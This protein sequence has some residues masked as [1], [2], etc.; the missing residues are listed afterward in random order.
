MADKVHRNPIRI[1]T[2][3]QER[4]AEAI[5]AL[6]S[7]ELLYNRNNKTLGIILEDEEGNNY[8]QIVSGLVDEVN[9]T[10]NENYETKLKEDIVIDSVTTQA[11]HNGVDWKS[12]S[13]FAKTSDGTDN[14]GDPRHVVL[15]CKQDLEKTKG[16]AF[17][18]GEMIEVGTGIYSHYQVS[19]TS[20]GSRLIKGASTFAKKAK[21]VIVKYNPTGEYYY[22][23]KF[24]S[25]I[26]ANIYFA[27]WADFPDE[28]KAPT[29]TEYGDSDVSELI[30]LDDDSDTGT[31]VVDIIIKPLVDYTWEFYDGYESLTTVSKSWTMSSITLS[32]RNS[33]INFK[34]NDGYSTGT[35]GYYYR[36]SFA[37]IE[38]SRVY[39]LGTGSTVARYNNYIRVSSGAGNHMII[40]VNED[41]ATISI[42]AYSSGNTSTGSKRT[43]RLVNT[44]TGEIVGEAKEINAWSD[45]T[46]T[47]VG[48]PKG[49]YYVYASGSMYY[50][51]MSLNGVAS[52]LNETQ[53]TGWTQ[54]GNNSGYDLG[55]EL[56]LLST[57]NTK[58]YSTNVAGNAGYII[59]PRGSF[60]DPMLSLNVYGN[61]SV[62][63]GFTATSNGNLVNVRLTES[64]NTQSSKWNSSVSRDS[65]TTSTVTEVTYTYTGNYGDLAT[66]YALAE[67]GAVNLLYVKLDY[68]AVG[69]SAGERI[70]N[71]IKMLPDTGED[72]SAHILR[73]TATLFK[74]DILTIA[75]NCLNTQCQIELDLSNCTVGGDATDWR[76]DG[77]LSK[78]FQGCSSLRKFIYP[79][80]VLSAGGMTFLNCAYLRYLV[81]NDECTAIGTGTTWT[82]ANT[83]CL[84]GARTNK[85]FLP[86]EL[87][88]WGGY[89][90]AQNNCLEFYFYPA[91]WYIRNGKGPADFGWVWNTFS[92][93]RGDFKFYLPSH[94]TSEGVWATTDDDIECYNQWKGVSKT[95]EGT[96]NTSLSDVMSNVDALQTTDKWADFVEPYDINEF[97]TEEEIA[98]F[99]AEMK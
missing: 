13:L 40:G 82:S 37:E 65:S 24:F 85:L 43:L 25:G 71:C 8:R 54:N 29:Y 90:F 23:I 39:F 6:K 70:V 61:C 28:L 67:T 45:T 94:Q 44:T 63:L 3:T 9:I 89:F 34:N 62:T 93:A 73:P 77:D 59:F 78:A 88:D 98:A 97:F 10:K 57:G 49:D 11:D 21:F 68:T 58:W 4:E 72:G 41:S 1:A 2:T 96:V 53:P 17:I 81:F 87:Q 99:K 33:T 80:G 35:S 75:Q 50:K 92:L 69:A 15:L 60:N 26:P 32:F 56:T 14:D 31:Q 48:I 18:G 42:T 79:K 91:N 74:A 51:T 76:T 7:R 95:F 66:I 5:A 19:M 30:E 38:N 64:L 86:K 36:G 84:S 22:G 12:Q 52:T 47:W 27:G 55:Y 20:T 16:I 46:V 83:G